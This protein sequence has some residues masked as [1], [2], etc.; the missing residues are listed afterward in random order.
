MHSFLIAKPI[1]DDLCF[2]ELHVHDCGL[3]QVLGWQRHRS[4]TP[5]SQLEIRVNGVSRPLLQFYRFE[6]ADV[7]DSLPTGICLEVNLGPE[8]IRTIELRWSGTTVFANEGLEIE[9]REPHYAR[10]R[11]TPQV[12]GRN[13]IYGFGPPNSSVH[14]DVASIAMRLRPPVL[15]FGCGIGALMRLLWS[16][17]IESH[18]IEIDRPAIRENLPAELK[19]YVTLY[20][21]TFPIPYPDKAFASV[22]CSEVLEHVPDY[23]GALREIVRVCR[24]TLFITV[25]DISVI[26]LLHKHNVVPWHLLESTH[27]NFFNQTSLRELLGRYFPTISFYRLAGCEINGTPYRESLAAL[28]SFE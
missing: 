16:S 18:G 9:C 11:S 15:D 17:G 7:P 23:E 21:G 25:P 14:P 5:A 28:C 6:R 2:D 12:L 3:I 22:V 20:N 13:D 26:P 27:L 8:T 10:L 19:P 1:H 24:G 4:V